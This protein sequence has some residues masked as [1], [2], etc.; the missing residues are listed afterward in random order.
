MDVEQYQG[1]AR[2]LINAKFQS[3]SNKEEQ[4]QV[5]LDDNSGEGRDSRNNLGVVRDAELLQIV[6]KKLQLLT[7]IMKRI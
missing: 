4:G 1:D 5:V 3:K 6:L 2:D 7:L